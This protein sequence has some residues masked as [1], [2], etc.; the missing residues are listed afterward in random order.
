MPQ[1]LGTI[2][3]TVT[4]EKKKVRLTNLPKVAQLEAA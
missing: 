3:I 4:H 1:K 2:V